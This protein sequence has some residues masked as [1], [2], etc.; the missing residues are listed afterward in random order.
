MALRREVTRRD[1][2][3][4]RERVLGA[5][6]LGLICAMRSP[7]CA[8]FIAAAALGSSLALDPSRP[9]HEAF[10][11]RWTKRD[12][13]RSNSIKEL[14]VTPDGYLWIGTE[15]GLSR[16]DGVRFT[17]FDA[18]RHPQLQGASVERMLRAGN[19]DL[20]LD[21]FGG[22]LH[23]DGDIFRQVAVRGAPDAVITWITRDEDGRVWGSFEGGAGPIESD[24]LVPNAPGAESEPAAA[25][26]HIG[27]TH[28]GGVLVMVEDR[29]H[30]VDGSVR[31]PLLWADGT[32]VTA[33]API[34][35][36][37]GGTW[38]AG[39]LGPFGRIVADRVVPIE[40]LASLTGRR[41]SFAYTEPGA[42][43][44]WL[45]LSGG[46][47]LRVRSVEGGALAVDDFTPLLDAG[48]V[49]F[50][51]FAADPA[52]A[53]W[54]ATD[55]A[56]LM[57]LS[58]APVSMLDARAGLP[59]AYYLGLFFDHE[60]RPWL[61]GT[62]G[63]CD[64]SARPIR[65]LG[66]EAGAP[67][68]P[69]MSAVAAGDDRVVVGSAGAG[70]FHFESGGL[71]AAPAEWS[72]LNAVVTSLAPL[73]SGGFASGGFGG[74]TRVDATGVA[75]HIAFPEGA[76]P[77]ISV[78][79]DGRGRIW[80]GTLRQGV[81]VVEDGAPR[82]LGPLTGR[83]ITATAL[84]AHADAMLVG[85][86]AGLQ[87][88]RGDE[89]VRTLTTAEGLG[90][91]NVMN[92]AMHEGMLFVG[93]NAGATAIPLAAIDEFAAGR[94]AGVDARHISADDG[95][96]DAE[97]RGGGSNSSMV[98][99]DGKVWFATPSGF[100]VLDPA[101]LRATVATPHPVI[102]EVV[103]DGSLLRLRGSTD[104]ERSLPPGTRQCVIH[105]TALRDPA[106]RR[107]VFRR[108]YDD[109]P[110]TDLGTERSVV[111]TN[112]RP[113]LHTFR[114]AAKGASGRWSD[115]AAVFEFRVR[116]YFWQTWW[117]YAAVLALLAGS[118]YA[119]HRAR[120]QRALALERVRMRIAS[121]L[122]DELGSS[123]SR[124]S[125]LSEVV[126]REVP[127][128][129]A[130]ATRAVGTIG[131]TARELIEATSD[132]VWSI[133]PRRDDLQS[134]VNRV[135]SFAADLFATEATTVH[136]DAP[137]DA[138]AVALGPSARRAIFLFLKEA[139]TNVA[140]HARATRVDVRI[141][142]V[143]R[144]VTVEVA[145]DGVGFDEARVPAGQRGGHGLSGQRA[146]ALDMGG[147]VTIAPRAEGGTR[148]R[149][150]LPALR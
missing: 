129:H 51:S 131:D 67:A 127:E 112:P 72:A 6:D 81:F 133:D 123:L 38:F 89:L 96:V 68:V 144:G 102:E 48:G 91:D 34:V 47:A 17:H 27:F 77:V 63:L 43:P 78:R 139:L 74:V 86:M 141:A 111:L 119:A 94:A 23:F 71:A 32:A 19:G 115:T 30:R 11:E 56:G 70:L 134:V 59:E 7:L 28:D 16:F 132:I 130:N 116:P 125:V 98:A 120:L 46:S 29:V 104:D 121:D 95:L 5:P 53:V 62:A 142:R 9:P 136:V 8:L 106:P 42:G 93:H 57:R 60:A 147:S 13:L 99:P 80:A 113:G 117:F 20:Y 79:E 103:C 22:V 73:A 12:G 25:G 14:E 118:A 88:W 145:D 126:R 36:P 15:T 54:V 39:D 64:A 146:R 137:P 2:G 150:D 37:D 135:R 122:H 61:M 55:G 100:A 75:A 105:F 84:L 107:L 82:G 149:L 41:L 138:S 18:A 21:T 4:S 1:V 90:N 110:W 114:V 148:V 58:D 108:S 85:T 35:A 92:L 49:E 44:L 109:G 140:R 3:K 65:C 83:E 87:I 33:G 124:I 24:E 52:G 128:G 26:R 69:L 143:G 40:E 31:R 10:V 66:P 97:V 101:R 76:T 50:E 45:S